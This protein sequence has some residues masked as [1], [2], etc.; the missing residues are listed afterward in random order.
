MT[1]TGYDFGE[2]TF[3]FFKLIARRPLGVLW[4]ALWQI[5][6]YA[7]L[8]AGAFMLL[9]PMLG[10]LMALAASGDEPETAA[11]MALVADM[12]ARY[13][14]LMLG[15]WLVA[16]LAQGAWLRLLTRDQIAPVIPM[17]LG[18]DELRLLVVN[19]GFIGLAI[20][21]GLAAAVIFALINVVIFAGLAGGA[22]GAGL[23]LLGAA[24]N[25]VWGLGAAV[26]VIIAAIRLA[27]APA[28]SVASRRIRFASSITATR[29][30]AGGMVL[31]YA[32]LIAIYIGG[33]M[34]VGVFQQ[35]V[36]LLAAADLLP[37]L[38]ALENTEDPQVV[39]TVLLQALTRP[40]TLIALGVVIFIQIAAQIV[41][42][43]A[44]HGVGAYVARREAANASS[45]GEGAPAGS[46]GAAPSQ[47]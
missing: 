46:V 9:A 30:L 16:L 11:I 1:Q 20:I 13:S 35:V 36:I 37:T 31:S 22:P 4:I 24:L 27:A 6:L 40:T 12:S 14:L 7:A 29:G 45:G 19:L 3:G 38:M 42:E 5:A 33:A 10:S 21:T 32:T 44:W 47:G 41:F 26:A 8:A 23:A 2:A 18:G 43:G 28:M 39:L 25:V 17:R 34:V 15:F